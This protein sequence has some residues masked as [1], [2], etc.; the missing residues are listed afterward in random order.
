MSDCRQPPPVA[1]TIL[2][3]L[4][5]STSELS[6]SQGPR[7]APRTA[8]GLASFGSKRLAFPVGDRPPPRASCV[9]YDLRV[10]P[11]Y[12]NTADG[13]LRRPIR[14]RISELFPLTIVDLYRSPR[15]YTLTGPIRRRHAG[16]EKDMLENPPCT[17]GDSLKSPSPDPET[18]SWFS[19]RCESER[20]DSI[21]PLSVSFPGTPTYGLTQAPIKTSLVSLTCYSSTVFRR[22]VMRFEGTLRAMPRDRNRCW[23]P[24]LLIGILSQ[25]G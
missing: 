8:S 5:L 21:R 9:S 12:L 14:S 3:G 25:N 1:F 2:Q 19:G 4:G 17:N 23:R 7:R 10:D 22:L 13:G 18:T 11:G 20:V 6:G 24:D 15:W 16:S